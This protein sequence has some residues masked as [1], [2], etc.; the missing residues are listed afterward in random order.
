MPEVIILRADYNNVKE[1]IKDTLYT[2][3]PPKRPS[4]VLLKPNL[5]SGNVPERAICTHPLLIKAL[6]ELLEDM[7][8]RVSITDNPGVTGYGA[9]IREARKAGIL[10][11]AGDRFINPARSAERVNVK[12]RF[13]DSFF[14]SGDI[15]HSEYVINLPK[16]KTHSLTLFSGGVKNMFGI[17]IGGEKA[18]AHS[19]APTREEFGELLLDIYNIRIPE[20]T[21][22]DAI[23]GM[24]GSGPS[25]GNMREIGRII[26]SSDGLAIDAVCALMMGIKPEDIPYLK[27]AI[28]RGILNVSEIKVSGD[29]EILKDFK[30][31]PSF[32]R[33]RIFGGPFIN[34]VNGFIFENF[35]RGSA[36]LKLN[37]KRCTRC[38]ICVRQCP[39]GA[40]KTD[41]DNFPYID[42]KTCIGCYCCDELC[43]ENAWRHSGIMQLIRN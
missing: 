7:G 25:N 23:F 42:R 4:S 32:S 40:M 27:V 37:K 43:P 19:I 5:L 2:L 28:N 31:P 17:L 41:R 22:M 35:L 16:F 20:L 21:I 34:F 15:L 30:L 36:R 13:T 26:I 24:E 10:D 1:R 29:F 33:A 9:S 6:I 12:S 11:I 38:H 8:I 18:R 39:V 14:V 3:L